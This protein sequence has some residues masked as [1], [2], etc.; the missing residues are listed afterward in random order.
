[1]FTSLSSISSQAGAVE[2]VRGVYD[3]GAIMQTWRGYAFYTNTYI[4]MS[5]IQ[6][7]Q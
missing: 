3:A 6:F 1:M 2:G 5:V 7:Q 4:Y